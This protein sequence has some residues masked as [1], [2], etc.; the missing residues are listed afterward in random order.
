MSLA[1]TSLFVETPLLTLPHCQWVNIIWASVWWWRTVQHMQISFRVVWRARLQVNL[2]KPCIQKFAQNDTWGQTRWATCTVLFCSSITFICSLLL[3]KI[4][5]VVAVWIWIYKIRISSHASSLGS[6]N[7][8]Y[9]SVR[10][11]ISIDLAQKHNFFSIVKQF[12]IQTWLPVSAV[13]IYLLHHYQNIKILLHFKS[14][15]SMLEIMGP[16][17]PFVELCFIS[18]DTSPEVW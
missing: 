11:H 12:V 14:V 6:I 1:W 4:T 16:Y 2:T 15:S 18:E 13:K 7:P 8:V 17:T 5:S 10:C 9:F 3:H